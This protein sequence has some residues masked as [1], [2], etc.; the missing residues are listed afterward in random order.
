MRL[1]I[2]I[3]S[4]AWLKYTARDPI[5]HVATPPM[6]AMNRECVAVKGLQSHGDYVEMPFGRNNK[7][8]DERNG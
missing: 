2:A 3:L 6:G 7:P 1:R 8:I 4:G 5:C